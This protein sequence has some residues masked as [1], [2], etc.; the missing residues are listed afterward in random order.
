M[1]AESIIKRL[2]KIKS[3]HTN[4]IGV[5][6]DCARYCV[7][8]ASPFS[9]SV[10]KT[11][12]G[13]KR[14][15]ID[16][17]GVLCNNTLAA[18]LYANTIYSK[19]QWF[20]LKAMK[21]EVEGIEV[22]DEELNKVLEQAAKKT[23]EVIS[24]SNCV[25]IYQRFL[26]NYC[27]FGTAAFYSE[28]N[29]N[30]ELICRQFDISNIYIA[31]NSKGIVDSVFR[32]FEYTARQAVQEF[33]E[34]NLSEEIKKAASSNNDQDKLFTFIHAVFP[35]K[36]RIKG[37]KTPDNMP[38]ASVYVELNAKKVVLEGGY[39]TMPYQTPRF[40]DTGETYGRCPAMDALP[41][42]RSLNSAQWGYLKN[43]EGQTKPILF[44]PEEVFDKMSLEFGSINP[45]NSQN[46]DIKVWTPTGDIRSPLEYIQ[47][48]KEE[49]SKV[50][51]N[52]VFQYLE[53]RKNMT[54]TE[55]QLRYEEMI[56]AV[57]PVLANLQ[58]E[59]FS[60]LIKRV[61][62]ELFDRKQILIPEQYLSKDGKL[63]D[64]EVV[65]V[66]RLDTKLKGVLNANLLNFVRML[67]EISAT[68]AQVPNAAAFVNFE[69]IV[70]ILAH[71]CNVSAEVLNSAE[72]VKQALEAMNQQAQMAQ[73]QN[74]FKQ[75]D[76]QKTPEKGSAQDLMLNG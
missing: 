10:A 16:I 27:G 46:G 76:V 35:R 64:F 62:L 37:K 19:E 23:L 25:P 24:A 43:V 74:M 17:Q 63:P 58:S 28:F 36:K 14:Q 65:Y 32:E 1:T 38:F 52:D 48:R 13:K 31:E 60:P 71:N 20:D 56:Q 30:N 53:D 11:V 7:P 51:Y 33:G 55:A 49:I 6:A 66:T 47:Q 12:G 70:K 75:I 5:W 57:S 68:L 67:A 4:F 18:F 54:A 21:K 2:G 44:A 3:R 26:R 73:I 15:P 39:K 41:A 9:S 72:D 59:F 69:Q 22:A 50:F 45:W 34:E 29:S 8:N 40:Y 61:V 42:L